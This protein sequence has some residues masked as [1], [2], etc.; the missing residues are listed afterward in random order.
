MANYAFKC[1]FLHKCREC[2]SISYRIQPAGG[3]EG[4]GTNT[5]VAD[6]GKKENLVSSLSKVLPKLAK[7]FHFYQNCH[8]LSLAPLPPK[9]LGAVCS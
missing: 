5:F 2:K 9:G 7:I 6:F 8:N 3:Q 4:P 1:V